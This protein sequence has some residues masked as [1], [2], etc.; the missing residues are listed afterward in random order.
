M[1]QNERLNGSVLGTRSLAQSTATDGSGTNA[2]TTT[3][4]QTS[5]DAPPTKRRRKSRWN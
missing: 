2:T 5:S 3:T 1:N 4:T